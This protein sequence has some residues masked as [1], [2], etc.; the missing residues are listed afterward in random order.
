MDLATIIGVVAGL[1]LILGAILLGGSLSAFIN[2][3]GLAIVFGGTIAAT[4]IMQRLNIVIGAIKVGLNVLVDRS[5]PP[6]SIIETIIRLA[7]I[8]RKDGLLAL[9]KEELNNPFLEKGIRLVVDGLNP[10]DVTAVLRTELMY[11]KQRHKRGQK[12]FKFMAATSPAMGMVGTLIGL[13]Q[14]LMTIDD[15]SAIGPAMAVAL[16]TTFYG[17]V[18]AFLFFGPIAA[19]LENRTQEESNRLEMIISGIVGIM[20]GENPRIIE[21]RLA[22]FLEP[23]SRVAVVTE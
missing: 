7:K 20:N 4:L 3:P 13:V 19:K 8:A 2:I 5:T 14:M 17:A 23:K 10:E 16:L 6:E 9:E 11:L 21:Q 22:S 15:P 1:G 18:L 12:V